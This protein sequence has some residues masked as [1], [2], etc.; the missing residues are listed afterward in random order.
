MGIIFGNR[1]LCQGQTATWATGRKSLTGVAIYIQYLLFLIICCLKEVKHFW[2][3]QSLIGITAVLCTESRDYGAEP[4]LCAC[5]YPTR[6][7][8][9]AQPNSTQ[10]P[11]HPLGL[12]STFRNQESGAAKGRKI[13][14]ASLWGWNI[15]DPRE[16]LSVCSSLPKHK[17]REKTFLAQAPDKRPH[18]DV[19][20]ICSPS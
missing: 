12:I 17:H 8:R 14:N 2:R 13:L 5:V 11:G 20:T 10:P 19:A 1:L 6:T 4:E 16:E 3:H 9:A 18:P 15:N 7:S